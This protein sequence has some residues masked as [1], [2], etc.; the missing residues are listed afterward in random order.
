MNAKYQ[1]STQKQL[2]NKLTKH[3]KHQ[4]K[5]TKNIKL[6]QKKKKEKKKI[7]ARA[8]KLTSPIHKNYLSCQEFYKQSI[9]PF[10]TMTNILKKYNELHK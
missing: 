3:Y 6:K 9:M 4:F 8:K 10:E 7:Q 1:P 5:R 2:P